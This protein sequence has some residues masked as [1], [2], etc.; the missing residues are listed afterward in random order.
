VRLRPQTLCV[1]S[2][3]HG[4]AAIAAAVR[5]ALLA[6]NVRLRPLYELAR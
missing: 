5:D 3:T 2:D 6:A 4:A 1:H